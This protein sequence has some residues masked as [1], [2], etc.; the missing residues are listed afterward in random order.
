[1]AQDRQ[2]DPDRTELLATRAPSA[3]PSVGETLAPG[4][5]LGRYRIEELLGRGGMGDVY[6][7]EQLE[8][9]R[10]TVALKLLRAQKL[11]ARRVAYFE[12]ERQ[13]LAQMR[14]PAIAQIFDA[15]ATPDGHPYFAMEFIAG[16]P[17]TDYCDAHALPLRERIALF[18]RVCEGVQHAHQKGV[19][20]RDLKPGNL[21]VDEVDGRALPKIIDFGIATATS[22]TEGR[23]AAG[24]PD[25][26]SPEQAGGDQALVDTRSDVFALGV[27]LGELLTGQR[28]NARGE[29]ET[30]GA[31]TL[32]LP[33]QQLSTLSPAD[34]GKVAHARSEPL[35]RMRRVLRNEL[36]WVVAKA[37]RFERGERYP[38][39]AALAEDLQRF[40]DG[41]P[42][43]AAPRTRRYVWRK[44]AQRHRTGILA[45]SLVALAL[46]GG[47][48]LSVYGLLQ[49]RAQRAIA[50][51][52]NAQ[53]EKVAAFQQSMLEGIDIESMGAGIA[54]DLR[55][56]VARQAPDE[57]PAFDL[58]LAHASTPD[59]ARSVIDRS[60]L[61][62]AERAI[63][64]DF[65][66]D[67]ALAADLRESVAR[68]RVALGLPDAAAAGFAQVAG[69]RARA[70]GEAAP[71]TLK[72]RQEQARALLDA[73]RAKDA[74]A[75]A[76]A[77]LHNAERL[78]ANDPL[79]IKLRLDQAGAITGLGDRPRA[80]R[81]L[82]TL[83]ADAIRLRG[84]RDPAT[85][86]VTNNLA[87]LLGRMGEPDAGRKLMEAL[88]PMRAQV[89]GKDD[90]DTLEARHN[91]AIMRV[92][93]GD[94]D[95]AVAMQR[96]Q[97]AIQT[98][99]LGAE[100]PTT[101]G[102]RG[103]LANML[104][105]SGKPEEAL[106]I[107]SAVVEAATRVL[108]AEHPQTLRAKLNL[109]T[110]YARLHQ[111]DKTLVMQQDVAEART[112]LLGPRHPDTLYILVNR[113]G[114][115]KQAGRPK[116]ALALATQLLPQVR[117]VLGEKHPQTQAALDIRGQSA[118]ALGDTALA[119]ASYRELLPL[120]EEAHGMDDNQTIMTAWRLQRLLR[121]QGDV[122]AADAL[123]ERYVAPL[124]RAKLDA[125]DGG[126]R[127]VRDMILEAER[128]GGPLEQP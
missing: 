31:H 67:P 5:Q 121:K 80:R 116:E 7:A 94:K 8:P 98:R 66:D 88:L 105:D 84:E 100:H 114:T 122:S 127:T 79:R 23:E 52:R 24:T 39:V 91:L 126:E 113:A 115:L 56:Q 41:Q 58:A 95:G 34:A 33:S 102:E 96:E 70:L 106:P 53:L 73:S 107:G 51:Q 47:L 78:P 109:S 64:R 117:E 6:R 57:A 86:E 72:A 74:L 10:R 101:L 97:V 119:I 36:D 99:R 93:T 125:L 15:G 50:E 12:V 42:V 69:Y 26:M 13:L 92:L 76:D 60:I 25:Y 28:P 62:N 43:Q 83:R 9:V 16:S 20:H 104:T 111:F 27:V 108:G 65:G 89:L 22:L 77:A 63:V 54:G 38:S 17:I 49:A 55:A 120:R 61:A 112:R 2:E 37:M 21:L 14:H 71:E 44:F 29:T 124:L 3:A 48:A 19:I 123:R 103:N 40:L 11:D 82:E 81:M 35:P 59:L 68:V 18:V 75:V 45:A 85:M 32:R 90:P 118:D 30:D 4:A 46:V 110:V 87:I 1:M 128:K